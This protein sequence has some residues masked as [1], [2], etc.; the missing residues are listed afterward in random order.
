VLTDFPSPEEL[1]AI[2]T[3]FFR[4]VGPV[5]VFINILDIAIVAYGIYRILLLIRGTRAVQL[6]NGLI[7]LLL[8][9]GLSDLLNLVTVNWVLQNT[10]L[11]LIVALPI[12]FQPELRRALEQLGR[13]HLFLRG[14]FTLGREDVSQLVDEVVRAAEIMSR[15]KL[16]A[17][18]VLERQTGLNDIIET[19][20]AVDAAVTAE[21]LVTIFNPRAP[22]HDGAV[23]I[24]GKRIA[25]AGCFL[26]L[27]DAEVSRELGSRH[28]AALGI[29]EQSDCLAVVVS[30]ETGGLSL[31]NG[32]KLVRRIDSRTLREMLLTLTEPPPTPYP[33]LL[34][35]RSSDG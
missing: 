30:E 28:R 27:T 11:A 25:A 22:L 2:L 20:L 14:I 19:G 18:I 3:T 12:V 8:A 33:S 26:P 10:W 34:H 24:R 35:R 31:A 32:G 1:K 16:G 6:I 4:V 21:L 17:I 29:T 7:V 9:T 15:N 13:G 5:D 23:I